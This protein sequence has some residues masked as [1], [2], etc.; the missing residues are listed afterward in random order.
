M[1][2]KKD[3][4]RVTRFLFRMKTLRQSQMLWQA[5]FRRSYHFVVAGGSAKPAECRPREVLGTHRRQSQQ[6][7]MELGL[8][9]SGGFRRADNLDC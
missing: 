6:S 4:E 9:F 5:S 7:R 3:I 8:R 2:L 1:N